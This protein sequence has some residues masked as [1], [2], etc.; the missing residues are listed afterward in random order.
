LVEKVIFATD[1]GSDVRSVRYDGSVVT[2]KQEVNG[3]IISEFS[4]MASELEKAQNFIS[5]FQI[6]IK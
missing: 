6:N 4:L 1:D 5:K 3:E 2:F